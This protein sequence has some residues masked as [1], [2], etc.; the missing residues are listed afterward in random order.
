MDLTIVVPVYNAEVYLAACVDSILC[1]TLPD[2]ELILVDDGSTDSSPVLCDCFAAADSRV[3]VIHQENGGLVCARKTGVRAAAGQ[4]I[5]FVDSDDYIKGDMYEKMLR[6]ALESDADIV[7]CALIFVYADGRE[8]PQQSLIKSGVFRGDAL[9]KFKKCMI[10]NGYNADTAI[11]PSLC[12][13]L[14]KKSLLEKS[15]AGIPNNISMGEDAAC[16][17]PCLFSAEAVAVLEDS[18][19][20]YRQHNTSMIYRYKKNYMEQTLLLAAVLFS[21]NDASGAGLAPQISQ[22]LRFFIINCIRNELRREN[23]ADMGEK[24]DTVRAWTKNP[25]IVELMACPDDKRMR[26]SDRLIWLLF[27]KKA[28]PVLCGLLYIKEQIK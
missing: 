18:L 26:K 28:V 14:V 19:Y 8:K 16:T 7:H 6:V 11:A 15:Q 23:P 25:V 2:F 1:Q 4:Y 21:A 13:K 12:T 17:Y 27:R 22:L 24:I 3:R 9:A 10:F 5:G 20:Y